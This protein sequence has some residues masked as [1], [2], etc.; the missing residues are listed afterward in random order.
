MSGQCGGGTTESGASRVESAALDLFQVA[1]LLLGNE[2]EAAGLVEEAFSRLR[3]DP[4]ADAGAAEEEA[5]PRLV[6]AGLG[7]LLRQHPTAFAVPP[8]AEADAT[9]IDVDDLDSAKITA[10]RVAAMLRDPVRSR[11]RE[12]IGRLA[13][14]HRA[15]FVLRAVAAQDTD[16]TVQALRRSGAAGVHLWGPAEVAAAYR[17]ALCSLASSL[18]TS[19]A[20][21]AP[22]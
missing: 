22:A 15:V 20:G 13:P 12:W 6:D 19:N 10:D 2:E 4:C 18:V 7:R 3:A 11:I 16:Q 9:C 5:K 17:E 8:A 14:A 21:M 1:A